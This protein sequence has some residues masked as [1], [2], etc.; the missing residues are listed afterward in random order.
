MGLIPT[1]GIR[2]TPM[3]IDIDKAAEELADLC[4][5]GTEDRDNDELKADIKAILARHT[6][7]HELED[8]MPEPM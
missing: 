7:H 4:R 6:H 1:G 5:A 8:Q 3:N 2:D